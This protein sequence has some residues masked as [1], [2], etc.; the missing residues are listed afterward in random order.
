MINEKK[1]IFITVGIVIIILVIVL[2]CFLKNPLTYSKACKN[3]EN[4]NYQ[5]AARQF[6]SLDNYKDSKEKYKKSKICH[7]KKT[8]DKLI[9]SDPITYEKTINYYKVYEK[10][11]T[12]MSDKY[13]S[14]LPQI[15]KSNLIHYSEYVQFLDYVFNYDE[16]NEKLNI[17]CSKNPFFGVNLKK[18]Y[19]NYYSK[20]ESETFIATDKYRYYNDT[21]TTTMSVDTRVILKLKDEGKGFSDSNFYEYL[22]VY[23]DFNG[24]RHNKFSDSVIVPISSL[25]S[26]KVITNESNLSSYYDSKQYIEEMGG[27][28]VAFVIN[29]AKK[30][31]TIKY[32][33]E[34]VKNEKIHI[35]SLKKQNN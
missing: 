32:A 6:D 31:P 8:I 16:S 20:Y 25:A 19:E 15:D 7:L 10:C 34:Y 26:I 13:F 1:R 18:F 33:P 24:S 2:I 17:D 3:F 21:V 35:L 12:I 14:E 27:S 30:T 5:T 23:V 4:K 29:F 11:S 22:R 28:N 9:S